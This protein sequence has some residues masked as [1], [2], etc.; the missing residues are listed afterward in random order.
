MRLVE[1]M[2]NLDP[3][4]YCFEF[5]CLSG[6]DGELASEVRLQGGAV[7]PLRLRAGFGA[8]FRH[9]LRTEGFDAVHSHVHWASGWILRLA[10]RERV[11][12]RICH[13][14]STWDGREEKLLRRM[15]N[16]V[17]K[18]WIDRYA[19]DIVGVSE[20]ALSSNIGPGW[21][22]DARCQVIYNG[23]DLSPFAIPAGRAG[24]RAEFGIAEDATVVIH[25]G[26]MDAPKNHERLMRIFAR[27]AALAPGVCLLLVGA[28]REP[29][30]SRVFAIMREKSLSGRVVFAGIRSDV[31]R[32][33]RASDLMIFPSH[34]EGLPGAV[35]EASAAGISVLATDLPGIREI[36]RE[37]P[38]VRTM[39]L[40]SSDEAW[41]AAAAALC[42]RPRS[43]SSHSFLESSFT[44][45]ES[46]ESHRRLYSSAAAWRP[47]HA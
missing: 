8:R 2:R 3:E 28:R 26:R 4:R 22:R 21:E 17:L 36:E 24:V 13:F 7:H 32:L 20:A 37:L 42:R 18:S 30:Q 31:P 15:R 19:T 33:L 44:M 38:E 25:V 39:S 10:A 11:E 23:I 41:A 12:Q 40:A 6:T 47:S 9:L 16:C 29:V 46:V 14:R 34:W 35:L 5:C 27:L 43:S 1:L 45:A